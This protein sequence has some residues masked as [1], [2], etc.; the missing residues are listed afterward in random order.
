MGSGMNKTYES[1]VAEEE[2]QAEDKF[3][4]LLK[5]TTDNATM[6]EREL[7]RAQ[8]RAVNRDPL[9]CRLKGQL[10]YVNALHKE[11]GA[12]GKPKIEPKIPDKKD[13]SDG[14]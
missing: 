12:N 10:D 11:M 13:E 1:D 8:I 2:P 3:E 14:G 9:C 4:K 6:L 7:Q 5:R